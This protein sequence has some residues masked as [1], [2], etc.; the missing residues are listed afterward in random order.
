[1]KIAN[2]YRSFGEEKGLARVVG[3]DEIRQND[4]NLNVT[5]YVMADEE[6]EK[7]DITKEYVEL[8]AITT[9]RQE[10]ERKFESLLLQI[11]EAETSGGDFD[12]PKK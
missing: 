6:G 5:L 7:I 1:V 2:A 10:A 9:E 8:K 11:I 12:E 4:Y 3:L